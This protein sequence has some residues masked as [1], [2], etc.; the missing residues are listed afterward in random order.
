MSVGL[1]VA[2]GARW[3][4]QGEAIDYVNVGPAVG[5]VEGEG[6]GAGGGILGDWRY[7][8]GE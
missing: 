4:A 5:A 2:M 6:T 3:A 1:Q 7:L 8:F